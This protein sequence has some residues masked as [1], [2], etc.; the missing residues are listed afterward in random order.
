MQTESTKHILVVD[1]EPILRESTSEILRGMGYRVTVCNNGS[2]ALELYRYNWQTFDVVILDM[3]MPVMAGPETFSQ[4]KKINP[5]IVALLASG[6]SLENDA[7]EIM[8]QGVKGFLQK[9][10]RMKQLLDQ[11][12]SLAS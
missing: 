7:Q 8:D 3:I 9:P 1:D 4:M 6:Y 5:D 10:Y 12:S 2:E 11:L